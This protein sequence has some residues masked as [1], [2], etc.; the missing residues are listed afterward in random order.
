M[1]SVRWLTM[2]EF[3]LRLIRKKLDSFVLADMVRCEQG[4]PTRT[5]LAEIL[6]LVRVVLPVARNSATGRSD[7]GNH[8]GGVSLSHRTRPAATSWRLKP[9]I[10]KNASFASVICPP[11]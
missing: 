1:E 11:R 4:P 9:H 7:C 3:S 5:I 10:L 2:M 6:F 8:S